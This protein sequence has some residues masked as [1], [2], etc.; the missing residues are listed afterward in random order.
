[1]V[2]TWFINYP[3]VING[4]IKLVAINSPKLLVAKTEGKLQELLVDNEQEVKQGQPL[5][6]LQSIG[7]H[8]QVLLLQENMNSIQ[9]YIVKDSLEILL[10]KP[11]PSFDHLGE[12]QSSYQDFQNNLK[13][14]L[15]L[16]SEGYYQKKKQALQK[17]LSYLSA[18][19]SNTQKQHELIKQDFDLQQ[20][21]YQANESLAR[22]KVI[23]QLELNQNKSKLLSKEQS[24]EQMAAEIINNSMAKESKKKEMLDLQKYVT[25]EQQKF[26]SAFFS[27]QSQIAEWLQQYVVVAPENGKVL[28]SSFFQENQLLTNGQEL[29]Y[30]QPPQSHYYG[31]MLTSQ[32]GLGKL[33]TG[34]K[35]IIRLESYPSTEFGYLSGTIEYISNIPT[36]RDS[37]LIKVNLPKGLNTNYNKTIL[38]RNNL[39]ARAE[40][41][42]DN[43][44]LFERFIGQLKNL[45]AR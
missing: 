33:K 21:E 14:T 11:L 28:F 32:T 1:M 8:R 3:D 19:Q 4:S 2:F 31:Q 43:R 41:L 26:K 5:A 39:D 15:Q 17:D 40:V 16:L 25:D 7:N 13:E 42:T 27:L 10:I 35:V 37:F 44:R 22:D 23:A 20:M 38:F 18:L 12:L 45:T 24:L 36:S 34:Q 6:F 9:S 29:F 30:I